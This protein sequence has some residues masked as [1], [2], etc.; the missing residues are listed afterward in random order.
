[1]TFPI[2]AGLPVP[3]ELAALAR[4]VPGRDVRPQA[5]ELLPTQVGGAV[6]GSSPTGTDFSDRVSE[7]L[8]DVTRLDA[9]ATQMADGYA[10]GEHDDVHGTLI[11][12]QEADVALR[13]TASVRNRVIEAY[14]EVMRMGA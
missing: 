6:S 2:G 7:F 9:N 12:M 10:R 11:A 8:G 5:P 3:P 14:R 4:E 13:F 1:M